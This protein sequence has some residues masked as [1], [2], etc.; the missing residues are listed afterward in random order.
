MH[1]I[2]C[3]IIIIIII[4]I[5]IMN[6]YVTHVWFKGILAKLG[7]DVKWMMKTLGSPA[8]YVTCSCVEWFSDSL[9]SYLQSINTSAPGTE[10]MTPAELCAM[11]PVNISI[12]FHN[13]R[14]INGLMPF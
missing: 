5:I 12:H 13:K 8:L 11:D 10:T 14:K 9:I 3:L 4:I 6:Y 7:M 1:V 2:N